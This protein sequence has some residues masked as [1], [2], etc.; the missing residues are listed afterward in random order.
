VAEVIKTNIDVAINTSKAAAELKKLQTQIN[1]FNL[2]LNKGSVD[3]LDASKRWASGLSDIVNNTKFFRAETVKMQTSAG[4]LD[5]VLKKGSATMGQFFSAAFNRRG[6]MFAETTALAAE[7]VRTLQTQFIATSKASGGMQDALAIRPLSAFSSQASIA[8]QRM[9]ILSAM[10]KQGT[11][12]LINF[13]KN[14]QWAGRQLMVG[15][16]VPLTI[17]GTA[18]TKVFRDLEKEVVNFK[19]V[20]GDLFTTDL[21]VETNLNAVKE[22]SKEF[23]KYGIA[24]KETMMLA[25]IGA[26]AGKEGAEL[27]AATIQATR[28]SVLGDIDRQTAMK[29][30]IALQSAF[31]L[32]NEEL[33]NSINF[34]NL[35]ENSSVVSLQNLTDAI[36]RVA[37]VIVGLGGDIKD[38]AVFLAAMQEGGVN[39]AE[40]ANG[41]KSSLGRLISPTK[42]A[43]EMASEFGISLE[44]IVEVNEGNVLG[45]VIS[46]SKAMEQL[47][48]LQKQQLLSAVFGKFQFARMGALFENITREGSQATRIIE[49]M[50]TSVEDLAATADKELGAIEDSIGTQLTSAIEKFKLEL[51]PIGELFA[52]ISI[53]LI[54]FAV[55]ILEAFNS[56]SDSR[57]TMLALATLVV[58][59]V[60][61]AFTMFFGLIMNLL[62]NL[63][64]FGQL[65]F[66]FFTNFVRKGPIGAI[67][68]LTQST[69]YLSLAEIDAANA[70]RQ[71]GSATEI[72][73]AAL[74]KQV[75]AGTSAAAAINA[76]T[77]SYKLLAAEQSRAAAT[78]PALF[79][80]GKTIIGKPLPIVKR[81][82]GGEIFTL[83]QGNRVP[84]VGNTDTV[85]AMLTPGEFVVNKESTQNNLDVLKAINSGTPMNLGGQMKGGI[86]HAM[87]GA[88]ASSFG[89]KRVSTFIGAKAGAFKG[90]GAAQRVT[91]QSGLG[92]SKKAQVVKKGLTKK[93][94]YVYALDRDMNQA[95]NGSGAYRRDKQMGVPLGHLKKD[96]T[97]EKALH[98][99]RGLTPEG[100]VF[101]EKAYLQQLTKEFDKI[102]NSHRG[103]QVR[104]L[105]DHAVSGFINTDKIQY[106]SVKETH[107]K[108]LLDILEK[109]HLEK[110][111]Q[112]T[113]TQGWFFRTRNRVLNDPDAK[114]LNLKKFYS[115]KV[116]KNNKPIT[117][118]HNDVLELPKVG[119]KG[120]IYPVRSSN[121]LLGRNEI[122]KEKGFYY[123]WDNKTKQYVEFKKMSPRD[124]TSGQ[125]GV[126]NAPKGTQASH[127]GFNK[128]NIVPG[129]GNTDTV[130]AM[131]TPGEFVINKKSTQENYD[132]L[133]AINNGMNVGGKVKGYNAGGM[134]EGVQFFED[135]GISQKLKGGLSMASMGL[136]FLPMM[137]EPMKQSANQMTKS[138]GEFVEKMQGAIYALAILGPLLL[139]VGGPVAGVIA[140]VVALGT[141]AWKLVGNMKEMRSSTSDFVKAM[142]GSTDITKKF[143]E[144]FKRQTASQKLAI[145][146]AEI[147]GGQIAEEVQQGASE[148]IKTDLGKQLIKEMQTVAAAGADV[149]EALRNQLSRQIIA[150]TMTT[151]EARAIAAEVGAALGDEKI[152]FKASAQITN[153]FGADG[154]KIDNNIAKIVAEIT[155]QIDE[156]L[157]KQ[158]AESAFEKSIS[159]IGVLLKPF[160]NRES[161]I[162]K[163][164]LKGM[165]E[166]ATQSALIEQDARAQV[167]LAL[168][169]NRI[170]AEKYLQTLKE[171]SGVS[172]GDGA[173]T[174]FMGK[175]GAEDLIAEQARIQKRMQ[176][177]EAEGFAEPEITVDILG[178]ATVRFSDQELR[179]EYNKLKA[180]L[181]SI[182]DNIRNDLSELNTALLNE[183]Q[184]SFTLVGRGD[185]FEQFTSNLNLLAQGTAG[186]KEQF[187]LMAVSGEIGFDSLIAL[188][189]MTEEEVDNVRKKLEETNTDILN[190]FALI[191]Q[192]PDSTTRS[193]IIELLF[194]GKPP[195]TDEV[196]NILEDVLSVKEIP[197]ELRNFLNIDMSDFDRIGFFADLAPEI[198][199]NYKKV[200]DYIRKTNKDLSNK[201]I[202][203]KI[204]SYFSGLEDPK[205]REIVE[206]LGGDLDPMNLDL[207]I[208]AIMTN[209]EVLEMFEAAAGPGGAPGSEQQ[210]TKDQGIAGVE[211][212]REQL[213]ARK[214]I[215]DLNIFGD[216]NN[217]GGGEKQKSRLQEFR[218]SYKETIKTAKDFYKVLASG[219]GAFDTENASLLYANGLLDVNAKQRKKVINEIKR[220]NSVQAALAF[221]QKS[222][223]ERAIE[224][225]EKRKNGIEKQ[226]NVLNNALSAK[227]R[228]NEI[229]QRQISI[230]QR[231]LELIS[232]QEQKVGE[233]YDKR[234]EALNKVEKAND[235]IARQ[236]QSQISLA[237]AL[238]SGDIGAAASVANQ[239]QSEFAQSQME[240][241]RAALE[242]QKQRELES[243]TTSINGQKFT[244]AQIEQQ[245]QDI[246]DRIYE[247]ELSM[248]PIQDQIFQKNELIRGVNEQIDLI[249]DQIKIKEEE[250][251]QRGLKII[252]NLGKRDKKGKKF[253]DKLTISNTLANDLNK[254]LGENISKTVTITTI[255][256][257]AGPDGK[258]AFGG[259]MGSF[260]MG[261]SVKKYAMGG[262]IGFRG[263]REAPPPVKMAFGS[264]APGLGNTDRVPALLTP[265]EFVVRKSV[266]K[267]NM[268][269]LKALNGNVFPS[270]F[271]P[272]T[273][274]AVPS[275]ILSSVQNTNN[276]Y[277]TY[278]VNVNVPNTNA[279]PEEIANVVINKIRR[280]SNSNV[281]GIRY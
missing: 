122:E 124:T 31:K 82:K 20:Y 86:L 187:M 22:L 118:Y 246:G 243:I 68:S 105:D 29:T 128:G 157:L 172:Q 9:T 233:V 83:N 66:G 89:A 223:E 268:G 241:T 186:L 14:V 6:T 132:L 184:T 5:S 88:I 201:D 279:S 24:A 54:N 254:T 28:L 256:K 111:L 247:R 271:G 39:A 85:P 153:F 67:T 220:M 104:F 130:P 47:T 212:Y 1:A 214:A 32:S 140:G 45:M 141:I 7:R 182:Q 37:P 185:S 125:L 60:V 70:A 174:S 109:N 27:Q 57:K 159:G 255:Y 139:S 149:S 116:D 264:I 193:V 273:P 23:T 107:S 97:S 10:F 176:E 275:T 12:N 169:E 164:E 95:L 26:Q 46:L 198:I 229:D 17:F 158:Q 137:A 216:N 257:G 242:A 134:A 244:R 165:A 75:G 195:S 138:T 248:L 33:A 115:E 143:A 43:K 144:E 73:N 114:A 192:I 117:K 119:K 240:D 113:A 155:P 76:L 77:A 91:A 156:R 161:E 127:V 84:G 72:T 194:N 167:T 142:Y 11:T 145:K 65:I 80:T 175:T 266:A 205:V 19:K 52:K 232:R 87:A 228:Q 150:Q 267:E 59:V 8:A 213:K 238:T 226:M 245:I 13:G 56:I 90:R 78:Q 131:L 121:K 21:E 94:N 49:M 74:L 96:M 92:S 210:F 258:R 120:V 249:K 206:A 173:F 235:R 252:E 146:Q 61:P 110:L 207:F 262:M 51:A 281:R 197:T 177:I 136:F 218:E 98:H 108:A 79:A 103:K 199:N 112:S 38:M 261:G 48:D 135:G 277:N 62:G 50:D 71:L 41:L 55:K 35:V 40:A 25:A 64:K 106:V 253:N 204:I 202:Q 278:S 209:P 162:Y 272:E 36:P 163:L 166:I 227:Q 215:T 276:L 280:A 200:S 160:L 217:G 208:T 151:E 180:S 93:S 224:E 148:F 171:I 102:K 126:P 15:F 231:G 129:V 225:L 221:L 154:Q 196:S 183:L 133:T 99:I 123:I 188:S 219:K 63:S 189:I 152:A 53:P 16:T 34:L 234:I 191:N 101:N 178:N 260:A 237:S 265:G 170:T 168:E 4:A 147:S 203:V 274:E 263:S 269:L 44:R 211:Q 58:G 179:N 251:I 18:A 259:V 3:Q 69:K 42:Q 81:N 190:Y 181:I 30:T 2:T 239:M 222:A 236:Q 270:S 100:A 250:E 230:R